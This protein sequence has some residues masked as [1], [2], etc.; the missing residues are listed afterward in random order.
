MGA[1]RDAALARP[2]SGSIQWKAVADTTRSNGPVPAKSSKEVTAT[3]TI[4]SPTLDRA[5]AI[6]DAPMSIA[7]TASPRPARLPVNW[8][9]PQPI[10]STEA[11]A[12]REPVATTASTTSAG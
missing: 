9:V 7:V 1:S 2:T 8:P 6:I 3:L 11:P 4:G 10:S 12:A 5:A